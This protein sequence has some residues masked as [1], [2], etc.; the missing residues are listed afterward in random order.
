MQSKVNIRKIELK[1]Y[2][3]IDKWWIEQGYD[4]VSKEILPM[5]GLG[6]LIVEKEKPIAA[7]YLYLTNSKMGYIDN[8]IS[9]PKYISKDRFDVI[10]NLMAACKK[11]AE[12]VGCLDIW[13]I[14][15]NK[16]IL[17]RCKKLGYNVTKTN[18]GLITYY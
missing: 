8:L 9:D 10:A 4:A 2:E 1:D 14:T 16:G 3:Y 11:M 6:G 15:N 7:A 13:A 18:Y 17:K 12:D 5:Q